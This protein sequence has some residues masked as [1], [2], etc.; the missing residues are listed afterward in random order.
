[1]LF[2]RVSF[3]VKVVVIGQS[4]GSQQTFEAPAGKSKTELISTSYLAAPGIGSHVNSGTKSSLCGATS[5][6]SG[7][8]VEGHS[9]ILDRCR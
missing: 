6:T 5:T 8:V 2:G 1:M 9:Q 7:V 4:T 3:G